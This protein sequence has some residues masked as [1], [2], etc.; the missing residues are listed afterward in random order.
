MT[1]EMRGEPAGSIGESVCDLLS[2]AALGAFVGLLLGLSVSDVV[3]AVVGALV[4]LLSAFFG[5]SAPKE[6]SP[7]PGRP[8]RLIGFGVC[9]IIALLGG[10]WMRTHETLSPSLKQ[11][12]AILQGAPLPPELARD[13]A[14]YKHVGIGPKD[15]ILVESAKQ[16]RGGLS[17]LFAGGPATCGQLEDRYAN[18][19]ER[20]RAFVRAGGVWKP[21]GDA[22]IKLD[23]A[24]RH[25]LLD[26][27]WKL[28]CEK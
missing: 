27:A 12:I 5:L 10:L 11:R 22:S 2:G 8:W 28:G 19:E 25:D 4:A 16:V 21:I 6:G 24:T 17:S 26:A 20:A 9:G 18:A 3:A 7:S 1:S 14:L 13:V 23:D 15:W